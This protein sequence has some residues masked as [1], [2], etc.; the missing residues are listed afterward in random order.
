MEKEANCLGSFISDDGDELCW[1]VTASIIKYLDAVVHLP[2]Q[3]F[4]DAN[5]RTQNSIIVASQCS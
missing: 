3:L 2:L 1:R 4:S 5:S